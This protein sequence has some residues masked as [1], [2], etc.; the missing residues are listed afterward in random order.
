[1]NETSLSRMR[2]AAQKLRDKNQAEIAD[3]IESCATDI[4][5]SHHALQAQTQA[6]LQRAAPA[7][8]KNAEHTLKTCDAKLDEM[9]TAFEN[10]TSNSM[11]TALN[12]M[13][14]E[15]TT[16]ISKVKLGERLIH[17]MKTEMPDDLTIPARQI[18]MEESGP[19][20]LQ[21]WM[22]AMAAITLIVM[23]ILGAILFSAQK[24]KSQILQ[25][26]TELT[27]I[28]ERIN[29]E[30][31]TLEAMRNQTMGIAFYRVENGMALKLPET[32]RLK[33]ASADVRNALGNP[34]RRNLYWIMER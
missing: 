2:A 6:L 12:Q 26:A 25:N 20:W 32:L 16:R 19:I 34:S 15:I 33:R 13:D 1:M 10:K 29:Q 22:I 5:S 21:R 3:L 24:T 28:R 9:T 8:S 14:Q 18:L 23:M 27:A 30:A 31:A 7:L 11:I 4:Q 17:K